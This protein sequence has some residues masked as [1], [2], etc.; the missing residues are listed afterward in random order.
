MGHKETAISWDLN[1]LPFQE[2]ILPIH[3]DMAEGPNNDLTGTF[4]TEGTS[5]FSIGVALYDELNIV[6]EFLSWSVIETNYILV[7]NGP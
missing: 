2:V 7:L 3:V 6:T 1:H 5:L 4:S